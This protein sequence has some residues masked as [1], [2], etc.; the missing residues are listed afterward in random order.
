MEDL[1]I[2]NV[3]AFAAGKPVLTPVPECQL[4]RPPAQ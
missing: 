1:L 4:A 2:A 3:D